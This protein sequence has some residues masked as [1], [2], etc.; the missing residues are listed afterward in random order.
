[1]N[2]LFTFDAATHNEA[3][4][5]LRPRELF[6]TAVAPPEIQCVTNVHAE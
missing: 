5:S 2:G 1:M 4:S 6:I 3:I